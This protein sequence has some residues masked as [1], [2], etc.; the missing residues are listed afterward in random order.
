MELDRKLKMGMV[1]GGRDAFIGAVHRKAALMDGKIEFIAGALSSDPEK[2]KASARDL[3]ISEDRSYGTW[4]EMVDK[5][6]NLPESDRIDFVSIVTPNFM[7]FPI[8]KG[9]AEAGIHVICDKPM[10]YSLQ[11]AKDLVDIVKN[12]GIVFALSHNYTGY[13]MVKQAR[14]TVRTGELGDILKI[15]VEYP[16]SWLLKSIEEGGQKQA[17]WRTD[18]K[19][20]GISNCMG[21]IGSHCENLAHYIT[22]LEIIEM[23]ADLKSILDRPLDNDGNILLHFEKEASGILHASQFSAGEENN[24]RI[25]VY[26]TEGSLEW[27]Q[28]EPNYLW[29]RTNQG[30]AQLYRRGNAYL[31]DAAQR[32][33]RL[34]PGHPEAFI[35]AFANIYVNATDA[36]RAKILGQEPDELVLDFPTVIDGARGL[37]FIESAVESGRS[38]Q[39]W[40][41]MK[42]Y[43]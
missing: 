9:F 25:R 2:A 18:P 11:E 12:S 7:H 31:C 4:Q 38:D 1:G 22:G 40:Y 27:H 8:A 43:M 37:A 3:L 19:R 21:D 28:E 17:S 13:P 26:G 35:E 34:P 10:T 5:E 36:M 42:V 16:Q 24:L 32:A 39:K 33:T 15:V 14:H 23:C 20:S 6:S 30:P 29:F 41:P